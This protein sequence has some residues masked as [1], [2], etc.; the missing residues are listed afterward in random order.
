MG[1]LPP[2]AEMQLRTLFGANA[3][4]FLDEA[5]RLFRKKID[6]INARYNAGQTLLQQSESEIQAE[7]H[8]LS[9]E[10]A[11]VR[12]KKLELDRAKE[13]AIQEARLAKEQSAKEF[14]AL[15]EAEVKK[16]IDKQLRNFGGS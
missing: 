3:Q 4:N 11:N 6:K 7:M 1:N 13:Q 10:L 16:Q 15:Q 12:G 14:L 5:E 8:L 9:R 2:D